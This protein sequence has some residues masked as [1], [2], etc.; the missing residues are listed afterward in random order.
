MKIIILTGTHL[1]HTF[2]RK[3]LA[4]SPGIQVLASFCEDSWGVLEKTFVTDIVGKTAQQK[5]IA[6]R[7]VSEEDFFGAFCRFVP[8]YS[9]PITLQR[10]TV[11]TPETLAHIQEFAPDVLVAYG[12]SLLQP[13]LLQN[14]YR[15]VLNVHLG[16]SPYY[17]G[18]ATNFWPLVNGEPEYVGATIMY[19]DKGIDTGEIIH[20]LRARFY[21]DDGPHQIGNRL[22]ADMTLVY[23]NIIQQFHQLAPMQQLQPSSKSKYYRRSDFTPESVTTLYAN[24]QDGMVSEYLANQVDRDVLVPL[25]HNPRVSA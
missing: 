13:T 14:F 21:H 19:M 10:G 4:L 20:Q 22:I 2:F 8:D 7:S 11:N 1:R 18:T 6:A 5:H 24:F 16:L 9:L 12:C 25:V 17:R 15:R 3:T 23:A